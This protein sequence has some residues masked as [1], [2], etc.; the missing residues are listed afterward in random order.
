MW[1]SLDSDSVVKAKGVE[2]SKGLSDTEVTD[3]QN[4]FGLNKFNEEKIPIFLSQNCC[5]VEVDY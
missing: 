5:V 4:K 1:H 3:R 2:P